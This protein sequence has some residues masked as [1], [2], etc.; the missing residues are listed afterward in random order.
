M[1]TSSFALQKSIEKLTI[2][3][4][5]LK[6]TK[7]RDMHDKKKMWTALISFGLALLFFMVELYLLFYTLKYVFAS[8]PAGPARNVKIV[9]LVFFTMPYTLLTAVVDPRF[10]S[11]VDKR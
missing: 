4:R 1:L 10:A 7:Q 8:T 5:E 9:L 3:I 2:S 6:E 11:F